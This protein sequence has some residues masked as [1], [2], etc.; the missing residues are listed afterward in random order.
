[1]LRKLTRIRVRLG[2]VLLCAGVLA[3]I[4]SV[5]RASTS[6]VENHAASRNALKN[7][8][9]IH[10]LKFFIDQSHP[11][12]G[13]TRDNARNFAPETEPTQNR[14]ASVASTG[15]SVAVIANASL[16]GFIS[17]EFAKQYVKK[18]LTFVRDHVPKRKGWFVHFYDW[19]TG[20]RIWNSEYSTI[21]T[22]L[23]LNGALYAC[24]VLRDS[25]VCRI[26]YQIYRDADFWDAMTDGAT[27]PDKRTLSMAYSET[28][29]YTHAQWDMFAEQM[30]LLV[31]GLG[32][33]LYPL[34]KETWLAFERRLKVLP[35]TERK[36]M[37][38]DQAL[39]VHHYS[40]LYIDFRKFSDGFD[41]YFVNSS[42][43]SRY[44]RDLATPDASAR[45]LREGFWGFSAGDSPHGY[46]VSNALS[47]EST[48]C[49][50]CAMA[51]APYF[52]EVVLQDAARWISGPY[53]DKI[54]GRYGLT[55]SVDLDH[56]WFSSTVFGITVGPEY[57]A[58]ANLEARTSIWREFMMIPEIGRGLRAA[59]RAIT[60]AR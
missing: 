14:V 53:R 2:H 58:L 32:H 33:P 60:A 27:Q 6:D 1:M 47:H 22:A 11:V 46:A 8:L 51:S 20:Q 5:S 45:T 38:L 16:R 37:G 9:Q 54:W 3:A 18:T 29:G 24:R 30:S 7:E 35:G 31:L 19:E 25:D 59:R 43:I 50:A 28:G 57:L 41:N 13:Q 4:A 39:F 52:P 21:D 26:T 17:R 44:H 42:L 56:D 36:V 34:P 12:T 10:A 55:D 23:L 15:F 49:I 48:V 40:Q